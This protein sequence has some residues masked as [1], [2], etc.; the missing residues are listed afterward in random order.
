MG[1][2]NLRTH[3]ALTVVVLAAFFASLKRDDLVELFH[4]VTSRVAVSSKIN[5]PTES[6]VASPD[7]PAGPL[8]P[9]PGKA[10]PLPISPNSQIPQPAL[11]QSLD[12][13]R[14]GDGTA[15]IEE[16]RN[17]YMQRLQSQFG[18]MPEGTMAPVPGA[19]FPPSGQAFAPPG[20]DLRPGEIPSPEDQVE[21]ESPDD[22]GDFEDDL[23]NDDET[24]DDAETDD[25][26]DDSTDDA[27]D[28]V[29]DEPDSDV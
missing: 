22:A 16:R 2:G 6:G 19:P 9:Q 17:Q 8:V 13:F 21:E 24:V 18:A 15:E 25:S 1:V 27:A 12:S 14:P 4:R 10:S 3:A 28:E 23:S 20:I 11:N 5:A 29:I 26:V 7:A